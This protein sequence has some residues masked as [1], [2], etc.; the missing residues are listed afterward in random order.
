MCV[1][2]FVLMQKQQNTCTFKKQFRNCFLFFLREYIGKCLLKKY[3]YR[4][5]TIQEKSK[6]AGKMPPYIPMK[7][8]QSYY[9]LCL[10]IG[11]YHS[12]SFPSSLP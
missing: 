5:R 8:K 12:S 2:V 9:I 3:I 10:V 11:K 7:N 4:W 1:C 6:I